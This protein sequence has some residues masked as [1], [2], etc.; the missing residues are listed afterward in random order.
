MIPG[1]IGQVFPQRCLM[2][3]TTSF[4]AKMASAYFMVTGLGLLLSTGFYEKMVRG[5]ASTDSVTVNLSGAVHFLV[6]VSVLIQHFRWASLPEA[7]VTLIG[8]AAMLKGAAL[9]AI[10][11]LTLRSPKTGRVALRCSGAGFIAVGAYLGYVS[12]G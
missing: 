10:P 9:I 3:E 6:G 11:E 7:V 12:V 8:L 5:N 2:D 4:F 1:K